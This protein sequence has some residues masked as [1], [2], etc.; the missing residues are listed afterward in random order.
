[1]SSKPE[2]TRPVSLPQ[3]CADS[4]REFCCC[5]NDFWFFAPTVHPLGGKLDVTRV[6][7]C[8]AAFLFFASTFG[9]TGYWYSAGAPQ[10]SGNLSTF[11]QTS[12]LAADSAWTLSPL[13]LTESS[14]VFYVF[15]VIGMLLS[16]AVAAGRGGVIAGI[17]LWV[18]VVTLGN[19]AMF[20]SG[21]S[22]SLLS[23]GLFGLMFGCGR[24][25]ESWLRSLS[26]RLIAVQATV[27]AVATSL[28]MFS[29]DV[30]WNGLG[31]FALASPVEDRAIDWTAGQS[32][33]A[34]TAVHDGITHALAFGLPI[35]LLLAWSGRTSLAGKTIL[36]LWCLV[37]ALLGSHWLY[38]IVFAATFTAIRP[39][40][41]SR[42]PDI[43]PGD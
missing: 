18:C 23:L 6:A 31:A 25:P 41:Y 43:C 1:M 24:E 12:D 30:W 35:G 8:V 37:V 38:G 42:R 5:W 40:T 21:I 11:L 33:L 29:R 34:N 3:R 13:F 16:V 28:A 32:L 10:S 22:E 19:R 4:C 17:A 26:G 7:M 27:V 20:L 2:Q 9:D 14:L 36:M 15:L 39:S